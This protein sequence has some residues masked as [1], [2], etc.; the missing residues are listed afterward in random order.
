MSFVLRVMEIG[1]IFV[2][3]CQPWTELHVHRA[4]LEFLLVLI[5]RDAR[6]YPF[7]PLSSQR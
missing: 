4:R 7:N 2:V 5:I 1:M 6:S 3:D